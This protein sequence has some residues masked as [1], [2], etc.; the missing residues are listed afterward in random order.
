MKIWGVNSE[1]SNTPLI[2][3]PFETASFCAR[4]ITIVTVSA[5]ALI[6]VII[7]GKNV[8]FYHLAA[9]IRIFVI[10]CTLRFPIFDLYVF[11]KQLQKVSIFLKVY[12]Y[13]FSNMF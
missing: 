6:I 4:E 8:S 9:E 5:L 3:F 10:S 13:D 12:C 2:S 7:M 1:N 11:S